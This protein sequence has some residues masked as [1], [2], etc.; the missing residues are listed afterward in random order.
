MDTNFSPQ[1]A[2]MKSLNDGPY[3]VKTATMFPA[4]ADGDLDGGG[5][6]SHG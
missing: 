3:N 6:V 2:E 5:H 1:D 4:G